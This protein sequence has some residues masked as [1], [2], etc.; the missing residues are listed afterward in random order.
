M[1]GEL[2]SWVIIDRGQIPNDAQ[3]IEYTCVACG[4]D[5]LLPV[6]GIAIAQT[7]SGI[8]FDCGG[9]M[10]PIIECPHCHRKLEAA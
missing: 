9:E 7:Q 3:E 8:V 6:V 2:P 4:H 1:A 5:A 10:P